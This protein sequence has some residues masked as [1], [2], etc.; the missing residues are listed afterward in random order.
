MKYKDNPAPAL[1]ITLGG[2]PHKARKKAAKGKLRQK[3]QNVYDSWKPTTPE[4]KA[5]DA[6]IKALLDKL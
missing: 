6:D 1:V 4:G 3:L 2:S 5:Y